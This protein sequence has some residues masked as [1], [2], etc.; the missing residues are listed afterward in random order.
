M[1]PYYSDES[2]TLYHGDCLEVLPG[3]ASAPRFHAVVTDPPYM[4]G[5]MSAGNLASKTGSWADMMNAAA[6]FTT[7]YRAALDATRNDGCMW[8]FMNWRSAPV[9]M[10]AAWEARVS[11][12]SVAVWDKQW[13]GPGGPIGLRPSYELIGLIA[14]P[15]FAIPDRGIADVIQH[16]VGS[17]KPTGHPAEKPVGLIE[18]LLEIS[19]IGPGSVIL[20]PFAGSGTTGL[21]A[22]LRG[23]DAVLVE[24]DERYC[25]IIAR[26]LAQGV[27]L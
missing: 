15:E 2:V 14:K 23:A 16:K 5:S 11:F 26:R 21:A 22:K 9:C 17:Y 27:L 10:K 12:T 8:T 7:W 1:K 19:G 25:E 24:A 20:D 3:L 6:W 18:R 4:V 13:I